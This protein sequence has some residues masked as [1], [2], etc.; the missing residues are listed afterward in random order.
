M[1]EVVSG[2]V[3]EMK[4]TVASVGQSLDQ[5]PPLSRSKHPSIS[6]A[7]SS[8]PIIVGNKCDISSIVSQIST[9]ASSDGRVGEGLVRLI[10]QT[11]MLN[12]SAV[13][14]KSGDSGGAS[15]T[16]S[17]AE[18]IRPI[19]RLR[20]TSTNNTTTLTASRTMTSS[21]LNLPP[22][23]DETKVWNSLTSTSSL[24]VPGVDSR[25]AEVSA[26]Y[27]QTAALDV[28]AVKKPIDKSAQAHQGKAKLVQTNSGRSS[29]AVRK[30]IN[31]VPSNTP[32]TGG[33]TDF[34]VGWK[35]DR[36]DCGLQRKEK[37]LSKM[38]EENEL[39]LKVIATNGSETIS[40]QNQLIRDDGSFFNVGGDSD[41]KHRTVC[42]EIQNCG[43]HVERISDQDDRCITPVSGMVTAENR[44]CNSEVLPT[45]THGG[46]TK[47]RGV[48]SH[49]SMGS[50]GDMMMPSLS[51]IRNVTISENENNTRIASTTSGTEGGRLCGIEKDLVSSRNTQT[52]S[53]AG[54]EE[55][56]QAH[57]LAGNE[58]D[59]K[60]HSLAGNGVRKARSL[61]GNE[62]MRKVHS[63]AGNEEVRNAHSLQSHN[64]A[65]NESVRKPHS[66]A[67]NEEV[68]KVHN[69]AGNSLQS[70]NLAGNENVRKPHS[71]ADNEK[72]GKVH[73]LA[74]NEDMRKVHSLAGNED[75]KGTSTRRGD[76]SGKAVGA[77]ANDVERLVSSP[78]GENVGSSIVNNF[79]LPSS[80]PA[81]VTTT[82][83]QVTGTSSSSIVNKNTAFTKSTT[84]EA[85]KLTTPVISGI[86]TS[87]KE[88]SVAGNA[89]S[90]SS[91][92]RQRHSQVSERTTQNISIAT[93]S[94]YDGSPSSSAAGA[95]RSRRENDA[96][97]LRRIAGR[98]GAGLTSN[99]TG[100]NVTTLGSANPT[101]SIFTSATGGAENRTID[102]NNRST[103]VS[104]NK[105]YVPT[106]AVTL[107]SMSSDTSWA[108]ANVSPDAPG[109]IFN[110][111]RPSTIYARGGVQQGIIN[112]LRSGG[113][114]A[115]FLSNE[116]F[117][118][119]S[120]G[121][122]GVSLLDPSSLPRTPL[123][124][125][126]RVTPSRGSSTVTQST[127][128]GGSLQRLVEDDIYSLQDD[129]D[130][131]H[132]RTV[133][134]QQL[135]SSTNL[136][137]RTDTPG[138]T[139][140]DSGRVSHP[141]D[142]LQDL[143]RTN[144]ESLS[145]SQQPI[146]WCNLV[147]YNYIFKFNQI[148]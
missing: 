100:A 62:D 79:I 1:T 148:K 81:C 66:L 136:L 104:C 134:I 64:L 51:G 53:L 118:S 50:S 140:S 2:G 143:G 91:I 132:S 97:E 121:H 38:N 84:V 3:V 30:A 20:M 16:S 85:N 17:F 111:P 135:G 77:H 106:S 146:G 116:E 129:Q 52:P 41:G 60:A 99:V 36:S 124:S 13:T 127:R 103:A 115:M 67:G 34:S 133:S 45:D 58:D 11:S 15:A 76:V 107:T 105:T 88:T 131:D 110:S 119:R 49:D 101:R 22:G 87:T 102:S 139:G 32:S 54:N 23:N 24:T 7:P 25:Y 138:G 39:S 43:A 69:L 5:M 83:T 14:G 108:L 57:S 70:H 93:I 71:L 72:V 82:V 10:K 46:N 130:S 74:G 94:S 33:I 68:G 92:P 147:I 27:M 96:G 48:H 122:A 89:L 144:V 4:S 95:A 29:T 18:T 59:K 141:P 98:D 40:K 142:V 114:N 47:D 21:D 117:A 145:T 75:V 26:P 55:V 125:G 78:A 6:V 28:N 126:T 56:R 109:D 73:N 137:G 90:D 42:G 19:V 65:G 44:V 61:A 112:D 31:N 123:R 35:L 128:R 9:A 37:W 86:P 80:I 12:F 63:L 120:T 113:E 8:G